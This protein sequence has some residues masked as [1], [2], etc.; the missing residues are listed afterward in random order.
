MLVGP[1]NFEISTCPLRAEYSASELRAHNMVPRLGIEPSYA[2]L[3]DRDI[4]FMLTRDYLLI[5][6]QNTQNF[7]EYICCKEN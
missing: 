1:E 5:W 3:K 4:T 2:G 7:S 6:Q